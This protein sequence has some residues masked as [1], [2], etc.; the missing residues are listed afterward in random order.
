MSWDNFIYVKGLIEESVIVANFIY[1]KGSSLTIMAS[2]CWNFESYYSKV[3]RWASCYF[4]IFL[5]STKWT[6]YYC[7]RRILIIDKLSYLFLIIFMWFSLIFWSLFSLHFLVLFFFLWRDLCK[8]IIK[9]QSRS[10]LML[11]R[12]FQHW[13]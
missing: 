8:M 13:Y 1:V 9:T 7:K 11:L 3:S 5:R 6:K 12:W 2:L 10:E 4:R